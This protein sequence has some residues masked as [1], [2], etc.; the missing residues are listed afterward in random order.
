MVGT[1]T[2]N[3]LP[4]DLTTNRQWKTADGVELL[5]LEEREMRGPSLARNIPLNDRFHR[6]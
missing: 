6:K 5:T 4:P 3:E 2:D 1:E